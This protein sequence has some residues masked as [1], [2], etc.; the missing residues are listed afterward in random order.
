MITNQYIGLGIAFVYFSF[1]GTMAI[2]W[3]R[4]D[5]KII[6]A[7]READENT[8]IGMAIHQALD[9]GTPT[10]EIMDMVRDQIEDDEHNILPIMP[11]VLG[12]GYDYIKSIL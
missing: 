3:N 9:D 6:C 5:A 4:K 7:L 1:V 11:E 10:L 8:F 2:L 12:N